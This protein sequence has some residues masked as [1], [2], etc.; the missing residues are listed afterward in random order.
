MKHYIHHTPGRLRIKIPAIRRKPHQ[1]AKVEDLFS[2]VAGIQTLTIKPLTGSAVFYFN[3]DELQAHQI[4]ALLKQHG[5][6]DA[7]KVV[8]QTEYIEGAAVNAAV[9]CS[10]AVFGWA[11]GRALEANGLSLLA[12]FI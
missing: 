11:I 5:Y 1:V 7:S 9:K 3:P 8:T 4:I 6:F 2:G 10:R 12:A